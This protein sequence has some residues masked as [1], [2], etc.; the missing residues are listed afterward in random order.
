MTCSSCGSP[1]ESSWNFLVGY[2]HG[3]GQYQITLAQVETPRRAV[4]KHWFEPG[5]AH[6]CRHLLNRI[7]I[8]VRSGLP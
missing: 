5:R 6:A 8:E 3:E 7:R 2:N 1:F 4:C